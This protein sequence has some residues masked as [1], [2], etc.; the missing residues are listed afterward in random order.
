MKVS[1]CSKIFYQYEIEVPDDLVHKSSIINY[2][3]CE[4]PILHNLSRV[5]E[6]AGID[7]DCEFA[8]IINEETGEFIL[9]GD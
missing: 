3:D 5:F 6:K 8:S 1:V 9:E 7:Y 2:C 4:D